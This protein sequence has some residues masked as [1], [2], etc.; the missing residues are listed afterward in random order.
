MLH[1]HVVDGVS[2]RILLD[3]L[4]NALAGRPLSVPGTSFRTWA[5][6]QSAED[7]ALNPVP[8]T[9]ATVTVTL[10]AEL[11]T[12]LLTKP[13]T[14]ADDVLLAGLVA[15][16][17]E[18][19]LVHVEGHG[20]DADLASTVG[21]FT[22]FRVV[23]LGVAAQQL[24]RTKEDLRQPATGTPRIAFNHLGRL[25]ADIVEFALLTDE[26]LAFAH[27]ID[28]TTYVRDG[29]LTAEWAFPTELFDSAEIARR[30]EAWV[31]AL[32]EIAAEP[33]GLTP[34]DVPL[35]EI[36]QTE[37]DRLRGVADVLPLSPLQQGLLF[38]ALYEHE[39]PYVGQLVLRFDGGFDPDR[40]RD[41]AVTVLTSHPQLRAGF[42]TRPSGAPIAVIPAETKVVWIRARRPRRLPRQGPG[43]RLQR[44]CG[45]RWCGSPRLGD[46]LV[47]T[48]HHLLLDGW[49]LPLLVS[50]LFAAYGGA[51]LPPARPIATT[52][53]GSRPGHRGRTQRLG[54]G[55]RRLHA[56]TAPARR[57]RALRA[58]SR[59]PEEPTTRLAKVARTHGLTLNTVVQGL[60][61]PA[62]RRGHRPRRRRVR[63]HRRQPPARATRRGVG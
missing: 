13:H 36:T 61:A 15:A 33:D 34:T 46:H 9:P 5:L 29:E 31:G 45:H 11:T 4:G 63:R 20:R 6:R 44:A 54:R 59:L 62:A 1:H 50:E 2:W 24:R 41:A 10:P 26:G 40:M 60:W 25:P 56:R 39:D 48:H 42:R 8:G 51:E 16:Q 57:R 30:A 14:T 17:G 58:R 7:I 22:E 38:L 49:S 18:E 43:A 28:I 21:W 37:L 23:R 32:H 3:D 53:P 19:L 55:A 35:V 27:E 47:I 52:W 12:A